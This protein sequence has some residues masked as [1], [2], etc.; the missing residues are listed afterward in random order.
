MDAATHSICVAASNVVSDWRASGFVD[1]G[2]MGI[3]ERMLSRENWLGDVVYA[4][5]PPTPTAHDAAAPH[6]EG[7]QPR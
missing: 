7:D 3:L 2:I 1:P 6:T 4:T 5:A